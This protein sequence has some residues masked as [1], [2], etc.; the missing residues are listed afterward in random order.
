[1]AGK[2]AGLPP[3]GPLCSDHVY[4]PRRAPGCC[5]RQPAPGVYRPVSRIRRRSPAARRRSALPGRAA[6]DAR[7]AAYLDPRSPLPPV[8]PLSRPGRRPDA[9]WARGATADRRFSAPG[10]SVGNPLSGEAAGVAAAVPLRRHDSG[11]NLAA[12]LGRGLPPSWHGRNRPKI[13][14]ALRVSG[15]AQQ[16]PAAQCGRWTCNLSLSS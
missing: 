9:G 6:R 12:A 10:P 4:H 13:P 3:A 15:G 2:P 14:G 1:M 16:Q 11:G 5:P 7:C 8:Y